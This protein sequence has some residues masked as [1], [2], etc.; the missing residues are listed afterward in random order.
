MMVD[1][2][3]VRGDEVGANGSGVTGLVGA[4]QGSVHLDVALVTLPPGERGAAELNPFEESFYVLE[5]RVVLQIAGQLH[6]LGHNDF[7]YVPV[8]VARRWENRSDQPA[9]LLRV[10]SPQPR[11]FG[12]LPRTADLADLD[13]SLVP[14]PVD[15]SDPASRLIGSFSDEHLPA[16]GPLQ[17]KGFRSG[18]ARNVGLWMLVDEVVGAVHHTLFMV[19]FAPTG[20]TVTLGGQHYHPFEEIYYIVEGEAMA[21]LEDESIPVG[22]GD[23]VFAGVN[24]LHGFSNQTDSRVRWIEAQAP[25]PPPAGAFFFP[26]Q[27]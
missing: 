14:A 27:W 1:W 19:Q 10:R 6:D 7:G 24:A 8:A 2:A 3:V 17:M 26:S 11:D 20:Q 12:I 15:P 13:L 16:P 9:T 5:G 22:V 23:V 4:A 18:T 25:A 21:H